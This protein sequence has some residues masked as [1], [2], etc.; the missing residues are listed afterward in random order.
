M[1]ATSVRLEGQILEIKGEG[2]PQNMPIQYC[3][4]LKTTLKNYEWTGPT[5]GPQRGGLFT[6]TFTGKRKETVNDT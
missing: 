3:N 6:F 2:Q 4:F 1:K 5:W